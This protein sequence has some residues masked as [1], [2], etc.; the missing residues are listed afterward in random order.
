MHNNENVYTNTGQDC[1]N[2]SQFW[3]F[4]ESYRFLKSAR[5]LF[6]LLTSVEE[7][8]D[9][10]ISFLF[11]CQ[12][13]LISFVSPF[14]FV[15]GQS[16]PWTDYIHDFLPFRKEIFHFLFSTFNP[17]LYSSHSL[18]KW[19]LIWLVFSFFPFFLI[20]EK[21][22]RK[23]MVNVLTLGWASLM[24]VFSF[25]LALVVWGRNGV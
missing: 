11:L 2:F 19:N 4:N 25:S 7:K 22:N 3:V 13:L 9:S 5:N 18:N 14:S 23:I 8:I 16:F 1:T 15:N 20:I 17:T 6:P 12:G 24:F 21:K 10:F